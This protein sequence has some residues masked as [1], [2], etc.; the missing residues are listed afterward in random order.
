MPRKSSLTCVPTAWHGRNAFLIG[1][2][3]VQ[4]VTLTGGGHIAEFRF[5][6][7]SPFS[8]LN[9]LWVPPWKTF[10]PF[11]YREK[12]HS[13]LYGSLLEGKLLS[14]IAGHNICLDYFG[15]PTLAEVRQGLSQHGEAPMSKWQKTERRAD[16][17]KASLTLATRLPG[18]GLAFSRNICLQRGA[19]V[20]YFTE[21][22]VNERKKDHFF[23][24][25]QHVTLGPPFLCARDT[26]VALP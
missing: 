3:S 19:P 14:G 25:T 12:A 7:A 2:E 6:D 15:P 5:T 18:A 4:L 22:V 26:V 20:A 13:R 24:W 10:E 23:H 16:R 11:N 21:T 1:N 17:Q 8:H 9:P